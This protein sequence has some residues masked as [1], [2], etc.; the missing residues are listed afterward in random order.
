[1]AQ[2]SATTLSFLWSGRVPGWVELAYSCLSHWLERGYCANLRSE[3]FRGRE[4]CV[5]AFRAPIMPG[6]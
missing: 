6:F 1:M 4:I 2:R 5:L 3:K